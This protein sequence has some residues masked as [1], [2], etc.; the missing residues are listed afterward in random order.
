MITAS[1]ALR[2]AKLPGLGPGISIRMTLVAYVGGA[3]AVQSVVGLI[4]VTS[5]CPAVTLLVFP[6]PNALNRT[7]LSCVATS[8][9]RLV[10]KSAAR[11]I[12]CELPLWGVYGSLVVQR[13]LLST[14]VTP[15]KFS[16]KKKQ[17]K[18]VLFACKL[19]VSVVFFD[20][21]FLH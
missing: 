12:R 16:A 5:G 18:H 19:N 2:G 3:P 7:L 9:L 21:T 11:N 17:H 1:T 14:A 4:D 6:G 20:L 13:R 8:L 15:H 10:L